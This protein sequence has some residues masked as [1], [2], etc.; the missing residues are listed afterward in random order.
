MLFIVG[1]ILL[2]IFIL[3]FAVT[4]SQLHQKKLQQ[5][6]L[7]AMSE[8]ARRYKNAFKEQAN[9]LSSLGLASPQIKHKYTS[10]AN[11]FFVFQSINE[12][13]LTFLK[14]LTDMFNNLMETINST[15]HSEELINVI[16][17]TAE[18][19]PTSARDFSSSFYANTAP[20]LIS[21]LISQIQAITPPENEEEAS[22]EELIED[23][24]IEEKPEDYGEREWST[25]TLS[26]IEKEQEQEQFGQTQHN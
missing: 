22:T 1:G 7:Y 2:V 19:I 16:E 26:S 23:G 13:N 21:E 3:I 25:T 5:E 4:F 14:S 20:K 24:V 9:K 17:Q 18:K 6:R 15:P 11:N 8:R 12:A 10:L